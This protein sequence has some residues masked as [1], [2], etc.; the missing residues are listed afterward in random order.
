MISAREGFRF[1]DG[2][3][4]N[5][6]D[7]G[8]LTRTTASGEVVPNIAGTGTQ[9]KLAKWLDN[10]GTL[11]DSVVTEASG[12]IGIGTPSPQAALHVIGNQFL[13]PVGATPT[14][15]VLAGSDPTTTVML[16]TD[17]SAFGWQIAPSNAAS[18]T[19]VQVLG[20][21]FASVPNRGEFGIYLGADGNS[22]FKVI[23]R[24]GPE[25]MRVNRNG[26][27]GVGTETPT[28][29]LH[30]AGN[31]LLTGNLTVNGALSGNGSGLTNLN[32]GN[33]TAGTLDNARLGV[34]STDKGGTGLSAA[35]A[36]G[37]F[38]RSDGSNWTSSQLTSSDVPN[39]SN[40]YIRNSTEPQTPG[41]FNI[42]DNGTMGGTLTAGGLTVDTNTL[43]VDAATNK[44][45]VGTNAP[46]SVLD[47]VGSQPPPVSDTNG[48]NA[49]EVLRVVGAKGGNTSALTAAAGNGAS[50]L[51]QSGDGGDINPFTASTPGN[52]GSIT[53]RPGSGGSG[54]PAF[55][56]AAG[57]VLLAPVEGNVGIATISPLAKLD[58][59]GGADA[60]GNNDRKAVAFSYWLGGYRHW[61]RTRHNAGA[62]AGNAIDFFVNSS[63]GS[64]ES[65][66]PGTGNV[67]VM[68]LDGGR[69]GIGT[70]VPEQTL[71]V[72]GE[73]FSAGAASGFKFRDRGSTSSPD[74][75]VWYSNEN[76]ARLFRN[77]PG[78]LLTVSTS[79]V[80]EL[81]G[82]GTAGGSPLCFNSSNQISLCSS[83]IRYKQNVHSFGSGLDLLNRLRPVTFNWKADHKADVGLVAE[84]VAA[85]E[86]LLATYNKNG[87]IEGVKYDRIGVVLINAVKEQQTQIESLQEL[88]EK[89]R[90]QINALTKLVCAKNSNTG[91]C[92]N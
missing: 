27:V 65:I 1:G 81:F 8:V 75:W 12:N 58:I 45:G 46:T 72:N 30:V 50:V 60:D 79:G 10:S 5:V 37:N 54:S 71:H 61:I 35:G 29:K 82:F 13:K 51:I 48:T 88:I 31:G 89:Q 49:T 47:V 69:V 3:T 73:I 55:P 20:Q 21:S 34:V 77:G 59:K 90:R 16:T 74:D 9:N 67:H 17:S 25:L 22:A 15:K 24:G 68:T 28:A 86:P 44:V 7:K 53:L 11:G 41:N 62:L 18:D 87:E 63:N 19:I 40:I 85:V 70:T 66:K 91:I 52:G 92:K 32:A 80:V 39:L 23:Q 4:L 64:G 78:D 43:Y 14:Y 84:E 57:N 6:N 83:S 33:I 36:A 42:S 56:G 76:I 26:N 2:S 38:L